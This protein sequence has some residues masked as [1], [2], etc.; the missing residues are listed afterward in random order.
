MT[1]YLLD[2]LSLVFRWLHVIAGVAW[3]G[4]SFYFVWLDNNLRAPPEW[5]KQKGIKGDLWAIHGGGFYEVAK[6]E[7]GPEKMPQTLHWFKWEA[8]T[9]WLTGMMML[10]IVY[11]ANA[12]SFMISPTTGI[13]SAN[14]SIIAG[15]VMIAVSVSFYELL[16]RTPLAK[17]GLYFAVVMVL[18]FTALSWLA[19][20]LFSPR[21]AYIHMG[22]AIGSIMAGNVFWGIMPSQKQFVAA[23]TANMPPDSIQI[24]KA[25]LRSL[26]N[27]YFTLPVIF[28]MISNHYSFVYSNELGWLW[29]ICIGIITAYA[30]HYFNLRNKGITKPSILVIAFFATLVLLIVMKPATYQVSESATDV[31][32]QQVMRVVQTHCMSCHAAK[33]TQAGFNAAPAGI[34]LETPQQLFSAKDRV[35]NATVYSDFMPLGNMTAMT[36]EERDLLAAWLLKDKH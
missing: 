12:Q 4:A 30:R 18:F 22:A 15:L 36:Q 17:K 2:W 24:V 1:A 6:Y 31:T 8:Y 23:V 13:S 19:F 16:I 11:Y 20:Q 3:I 32:D 34:V 5:K 33:P 25:Q 26:H 28:I 10:W 14:V 9:T 21:A 7:L 27:N 29:L 35:L